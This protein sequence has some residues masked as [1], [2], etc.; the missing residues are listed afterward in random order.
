MSWSWH[1]ATGSSNEQ[2]T[3]KQDILDEAAQEGIATMEESVV[4]LKPS[5][6]SSTS[7]LQESWPH[8]LDGLAWHSLD[9]KA[10]SHHEER[11]NGKTQTDFL[12]NKAPFYC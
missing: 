2:H 5:L 4:F 7:R 6:S 10:P 1:Q 3:W 9:A 12:L 8:G 11:S